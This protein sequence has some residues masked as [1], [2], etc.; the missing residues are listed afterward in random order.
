MNDTRTIFSIIICT[1]N[2]AKKIGKSLQSLV[3]QEFPKNQFEIIVV[4]D[5]STDNTLE[6]ISNYQVK[7]IDNKINKGIA[8]SRNIGLNNSSGDI[9]VC[10]DD[11]CSVNNN[12]LNELGKKYQDKKVVGVA[13]NLTVPNNSTLIDRYFA[14]IWYGVASPKQKV[15]KTIL[16]RLMWYYSN[17]PWQ[18]E[19]P[20]YVEGAEI[21]DVP[22][23][24]SSYRTELLKQ[25]GG[26]DD[27]LVNSSEDND[28]SNKML[29]NF[30]DKKIV[31]AKNAIV[32]HYQELSFVD[33]LRR[34]TQRIKWRKLFYKKNKM[35]PVIF[36]Q[37]ILLLFLLLFVQ[38]PLLIFLLPFV[39]YPWWLFRFFAKNN[40]Q[41][42]AFPYIQLIQETNSN[43]AIIKSYLYE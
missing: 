33:T 20:G 3:D 37:P 35:F 25:I 17:S 9:I 43:I 21:V 22:A 24:C 14:S 19:K 30:P 32:V 39:V 8:I 41:F 28:L 5:G 10:I 15:K 11:D 34:E 23:A 31:L 40:P 29:S 12:F 26:W 2:G 13:G 42:L 27:Q 7:I 6:V 16:D 1:Y 4:V 18:S 38:L 36:P